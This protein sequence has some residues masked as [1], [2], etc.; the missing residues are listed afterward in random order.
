LA[1]QQGLISENLQPPFVA[2][3]CRG[4]AKFGK[5]PGLAVDKRRDTE[6]LR[7]RR[8]SPSDAARSLRSTKWVLTRRSA[9]KRSA[10]LVSVL[11]FV[12]NTWTSI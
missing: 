7:N 6:L 8:S 10:F 9:K 5:A 3:P 1:Q 12:P 11:F 2:V 4:K